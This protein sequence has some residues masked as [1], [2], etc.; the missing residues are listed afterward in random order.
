VLGGLLYLVDNLDI[1]FFV[2]GEDCGV[3]GSHDVLAV[4][5]PERLQ[6]SLRIVDALVIAYIHEH[7]VVAH[8]GFPSA[9]IA[10]IVTFLASRPWHQTN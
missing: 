6:V 10:A 7:R 2:L 5:F 1:A 8:L 3:I 9:S 4:Q